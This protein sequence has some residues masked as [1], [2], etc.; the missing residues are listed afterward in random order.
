VLTD[1]A[2]EGGRSTYTHEGGKAPFPAHVLLPTL[3]EKVVVDH[4]PPTECTHGMGGVE[5]E[6][7]EKVGS[8]LIEAKVENGYLF[9]LPA[10]ASLASKEYS[11]PPY[12]RT[13]KID[14]D[15]EEQKAP[16]ARQLLRRYPNG[17]SG[18]SPRTGPTLKPKYDADSFEDPLCDEFWEDTWA[19]CAM[20]NVSV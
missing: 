15:V 8:A 9:G 10:D 19:A 20:H 11:Q 14:M 12:V 3:E 17:K 5:G 18:Q 1:T 16:R 4:Q 6:V 13:G 7:Q 2:L